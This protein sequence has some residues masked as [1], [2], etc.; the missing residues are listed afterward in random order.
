[1]KKFSLLFVFLLTLVGGTRAFADTL[2]ENF[3]NITRL[4]KD[5]N[6][7]TSQWSYGYSLSNGWFV[8][9]AANAISASKTMNYGIAAGGYEGNAIWAGYGSSNSYYMVIPVL[10]TGEITFKAYKNT[11]T[12]TPSIKFFEVTESEGSFTVTDTQLG[13]TV[14]PSSASWEDYSINIGDEGKYIALNMIYAGLDNFEA[15]IFSESGTVAKPTNVTVDAVTYNSATL[16]W[17]A[18]GEET[19]WQLVFDAAADF[20]RDAATPITISENPY[21]LTGLAEGTTYYAYLRAKAGDEVSGWSSKISFTTP[22]QFPQPTA[23]ALTGFTATTASFSWTAGS[24]ETAWQIA[25]GTTADFDPA[26]GGT[27]VDA[28]ANP[29]T[30]EGLTAEKTYY[31]C[32]RANYGGGNYSAWGEK[33]S[34]MPS[35]VI[36]IT[37]NEGTNT[38]MYIPFNGSYT[39]TEGTM[40]QFIIPADLLKDIVDRSITKMT[41]YTNNT[42]EWGAKFKVFIKEVSETTFSSKECEWDG[43]DEVA[44]ITVNAPDGEMAIDFDT[45]YDYS[46]SNLMVGFSLTQKGS[47]VS[48]SWYGVSSGANTARYSFQGWGGN[49]N[50]FASFM[51]KT[52]IASI[53]GS[54]I[55]KPKLSVTKPESLDYGIIT[56]AADK[57]FTIANTGNATL[58]GIAITS[59]N[60][61][62]TVKNAPT[63][64][65]AGNSAVVTITMSATTMGEQSSTITISA[66]NVT[67]TVDFTVKGVTLPADMTVVDFED[68]QLPARW[69]NSGYNG[70]WTFNG[71]AAYAGYSPSTTRPVMTTPKIVVND[72]DQLVLRAKLDN[73][74]SIYYITVK[75]SSDNG[76]NWTAYTKKIDSNT[77]ST[78]YKAIVLTDIPSTVNRLQFEGYYASIDEIWGIN[79]AAELAVKKGE[80]AVASPTTYD[81]GETN[82]E[83]SVTYNFANAGIGTINITGVAI[84]GDGAAAY[85]TNWKESVAT[86]FDLVIT[87]SY[88]ATRTAAQEATVTVSTSEGDFVI[89]VTGTD[90]AANQPELAVDL[91]SLKFGTLTANATKTVTVTNSGTGL[92]TVNIASDSEDFTVSTTKLEGITAGASQT[93]DV[94]FNYTAGN[95]GSKTGNITVTPTYDETAVVTIAATAKAKDPNVWSEDFSGNA[96]PTGWDSESNWSFDTGVAK[97]A[98]G[99]SSTGYKYYLTTPTLTVSDVTEE[100]TFDYSA[101]GNYVSIKIQ[102]SKNGAAFT[103][104]KTVSLDNGD[105]GTYTITGLEAGNYQ[106]RFA[107][108]DYELDNFEGFTL[109][110]ADHIIVI[111]ASSIP[112]STSWSTTMKVSRS[113]DATITLKENRGNDEEVTAKVYMGETVIGQTT[114]IVEANTS[115]TLTIT[116]TPTVASTSGAE[117]H[118]EVDYAGGTLST[119]AVTRYVDALTYLTLDENSSDAIQAG[120]YDEV[121]LKLS[122][123]QGWNTLCLPFAISDIEELIGTGAKAYD[124]TSYTNNEVHFTSA[125]TLKSS[126]PYLIYVPT[127]ITDDIALTDITIASSDVEGWYTRNNDAYLRGTYAPMEAGT[128]TGK[129]V[130]TETEG[131]PTFVKATEETALKGFRAYLELPSDLFDLYIDNENITTG[132]QHITNTPGTDERI[133]NLNGQR[134]TKPAKNGITIIRSATNGKSIKMIRK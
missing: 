133:Y 92:L 99:T 80:E 49:T 124:F 14:T 97:A 10:L 33:I 123:A 107:N 110:L 93:F 83:T 134:I 35:A 22:E 6:E 47:Y 100:L 21:T 4:D 32:L 113:F 39:D 5:G 75:G 59:S 41:F 67:K 70:G 89:N 117:M 120:T 2:T 1:M 36:N 45:P 98:Y 74:T 122:F 24:T 15:E 65:E 11:S 82:T 112:E 96:L 88:D 34:F 38:N 7:I 86:P 76:E 40:G 131:I 66:A 73:T 81:F 17:T 71:G 19:Q 118:I 29:F 90:K 125:T 51:P 26:T 69:E 105:A 87:R 132:I 108:D 84:T 116:C 18:G 44:E 106:F 25:Y 53:P 58:E 43:M 42:K 12:K 126:F 85:S 127:A 114:D 54:G 46:G 101:T 72:G 30:L 16:S 55:A 109:N 52:T 115:K 79:N 78:E 103:D 3:D 68:N 23:F 27:I 20:D 129:F 9:P 28:T 104:Y 48:T 64:L 61:A 60:A 56:A 95:Y 130:L 50:D 63:T 57:T 121:T 94:T 62:F 111:A 13:E 91:T 37:V 8:S 77:L 119:E 31:A 102:M 128:L